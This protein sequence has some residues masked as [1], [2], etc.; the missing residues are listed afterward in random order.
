MR[1]PCYYRQSGSATTSTWPAPFLRTRAF[2]SAGVAGRLLA[3]LPTA[4][5]RCPLGSLEVVQLTE[6]G[7]TLEHA[8]LAIVIPAVARITG[9]ARRF[10]V[11]EA[12]AET[13]LSAAS[14]TPL[15]T[16]LASTGLALMAVQR[17]AVLAAQ[18]QYPTLE[19]ERGAE[20][21]VILGIQ[22]KGLLGLL[23]QTMGNL[24]Q[25]AEHFEDAL[26]FSRKAGY[27]PELA[28]TCCDYAATLLQR[29]A[30]GDRDKA[31]SLLD[32]SLGV[33]SELGMRPLMERVI[34][35]QDSLQA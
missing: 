28:W 17:C 6:P 26:A 1:R 16:T 10:D 2:P 5:W 14:H 20:V 29:D 4:V 31:T 21:T 24:N 7:P 34:S 12:A 11:A 33:S 35:R 13:I 3:T 25:A 9:V 19:T 27:R 8:F 15:V 23:A 30:S 32:E 22:P 18:R